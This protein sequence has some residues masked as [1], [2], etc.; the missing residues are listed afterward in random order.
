M[1]SRNQVRIVHITTVHRPFD[2]RCFHK[3][4][5]ST[6]EAGFDTIMIQR[7]EREEIVAGVRVIPLPSYTS[8]PARMIRGV[9]AATRISLRERADVVHFH[10]PEV[11][12]GGVILKLFGK[13]VVYDVHENL[14]LD[15]AAKQWLPAWAKGPLGLATQLLEWTAARVLDRIVAATDGIAERFPPAKTVLVKNAPII[16]D[17]R[18]PASNVPLAER[19]ANMIYIGGLGGGGDVKGVDLMLNALAALPPASPIRLI[20]GGPEPS[21][22]FIEA[23]KGKPGG[24]RVDYLGY[25]DPK[26]LGEHYAGAIG[27]LILYPPAPN[28]IASEPVKLFEAMAAG[29]P[30]LLSNFPLFVE[31]IETVKCGFALDPSDAELVARRMTEL[32]EDRALAQRLGDNGRHY[33]ETERNWPIF[34]S[35]MVAMYDELTGSG[36]VAPTAAQDEKRRAA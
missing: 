3:A 22:G 17:L 20:L 1:Q 7:G 12:W 34:A 24:G 9:L 21:P 16:A 27:A 18:V 26:A 6:A 29:V 35:R 8:R 23:L 4:A 13:K 10:D 19:P 2:M 36:P 31:Y 28:S 15:I 14:H 33:V 32:H 5:V 25:V 30:A 11:I